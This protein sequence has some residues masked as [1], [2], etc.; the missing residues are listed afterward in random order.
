MLNYRNSP[1]F[2]PALFFPVAFPHGLKLAL[3]SLASPELGALCMLLLESLQLPQE[4][5]V[6]LILEL[7]NRDSEVWVSRLERKPRWRLES[8]K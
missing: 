4:T 6:I 3:M 1:H 7:E 8:P 5:D 2:L